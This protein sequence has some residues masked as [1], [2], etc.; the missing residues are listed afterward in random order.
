[1]KRRWLI[2][3]GVVLALLIAGLYLD[4]TCVGLG[5]LK[6]EAFYRGRPTAYWS[7]SLRESD[8][9]ARAETVK[10]LKEGGADAV[11]VLVELL[12]GPKSDDWT[13]AEVRWRAADLLGQMGPQAKAAT[14]A[15]LR[16]A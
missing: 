15:L 6:R 12:D 7:K 8:P 3:A 13:A 2:G 4:P 10:S 9:E 16:A 14:P 1:M 11:P 5:I